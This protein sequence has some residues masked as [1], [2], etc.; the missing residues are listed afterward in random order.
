MLEAFSPVAGSERDW[1]PD[2]SSNPDLNRVVDRIRK[3]IP[4]R[5]DL[6]ERLYRHFVGKPLKHGTDP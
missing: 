4:K 5:I 6:L 3:E 2:A 1:P